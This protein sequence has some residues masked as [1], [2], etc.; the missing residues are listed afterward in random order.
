LLAR[1]PFVHPVA[2]VGVRR[3]HFVA[4]AVVQRQA[5]S[6]AE[7]IL[8]IP[9]RDPLAQAA[10][11]VAAALEEL[12]RLPQQQTRKGIAGRKWREHEESVGGDSQQHVDLL[13]I[14]VGA[15]LQV[16]PAARHGDRVDPW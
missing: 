3:I 2:N 10:V 7:L 6:D 9:R 5:R 8:R 13:A 15:Q 16:M 12:H 11:E 4:Q 14:Q 1:R